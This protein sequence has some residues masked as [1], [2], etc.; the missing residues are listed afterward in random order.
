MSFRLLH[1]VYLMKQFF[2]LKIQDMKYFATY[3]T[4][5]QHILSEYKTYNLPRLKPI[6][7]EVGLNFALKGYA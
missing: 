1:S 6:R 7:I 2:C 5:C 4:K 3:F